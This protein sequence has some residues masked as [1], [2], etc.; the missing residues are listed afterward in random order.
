MAGRSLVICGTRPQLLKTSRLWADVIVDTG[1]HYD[2]EMVQ[3]LK[4]DYKLKTTDLGQMIDKLIPVIKKEKPSVICVIGDT[5]STLAGA[6]VAKFFGIPLVHIEAGMRSYEDMPE[7]HIRVV[8]DK[9]ADYHLATT[10]YCVDNLDKEGIY[11]SILISDPEFE[12][13]YEL[14]PLKGKYWTEKPEQPY[15]LLTL[16]RQA[17]LENKK[18]FTAV[19]KTLGK[20]PDNFIFPCHPH[21]RK[22]MNEYGIKV[23]HNIHLIRPVKHKELIKL[24]LHAEKV[25]TDS[26]GVQRE[27]YWLAKDVI[28]LRDRTEHY[29]IITLECGVLVGH[30]PEKLREAILNFKGKRTPLIPGGYSHERIKATIEDIV[31]LPDAY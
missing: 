26:G 30:D 25:V 6:T 31:G 23:P 17:L 15:C 7:E 4:P 3:G 18:A 10:Q 11:N 16:H 9:M 8:V 24:I 1:Q 12:P 5:R 28:I 2:K 29:D 13:L 14:M 27:A 20:L 22:K 19:I 21:T